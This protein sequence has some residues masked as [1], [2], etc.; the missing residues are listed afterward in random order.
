MKV[1]NLILMM[2]LFVG[3]TSLADETVPK[4]NASMRVSILVAK[5]EKVEIGDPNVVTLSWRAGEKYT[6]NLSDFSNGNATKVT[7]SDQGTLTTHMELLT[8][9]NQQSI[10]IFVRYLSKDQTEKGNIYIYEIF[11]SP[12]NSESGACEKPEDV[13]NISIK[14][15][16]RQK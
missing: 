15:S 5:C 16:T 12:L 14:V 3:A 11:G 10:K 2:S 1:S 7:T 6:V 8:F 4:A 9:P 13:G